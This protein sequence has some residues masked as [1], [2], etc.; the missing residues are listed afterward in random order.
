MTTYYA[1]FVEVMSGTLPVTYTAGAAMAYDRMD[2]DKQQAIRSDAE[3]FLKDLATQ[4]R[5][6]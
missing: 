5:T 1:Y 6:P 4:D 3:Q 2:A